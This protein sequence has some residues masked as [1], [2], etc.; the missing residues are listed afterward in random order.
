MRPASF[1][2]SLLPL[3][4]ATLLA[5]QANPV[6]EPP[7]DGQLTTPYRVEVLARDLHVPWAITFLP[8]R[9]IFFTERT[10]A[11]RV[12]H[13]DQLLPDA[14]LTIDVAQ[15]NKMGMLGLV[16]D[17]HFARNHFLY[18][19]YDYNVQPV[20]PAHPQYR[21]RIVRYVERKDKLI[22]PK[23]LLEDIPAWTNHTGGRMRFAPDGTL[24]ITTGDANE[25]PM[26]QRPDVLNGK[27][28]RIYSDGTVP[29]DNPFVHQRGA[30]PEIWS[31]GHRNP[32]GID[33][34]PGSGR[35]IETE[36]GPLGGDEVNWILPGHNYGWP[37]IDHRKTHEGMESP[38]LEFSPSIAPGTASFY[39]GKTFPELKGNV[40]VGCLRGEGILRI[41]L[42]G[43]NVRHASWLFHRTFG[44]IREITESPEGYLYIS[45]SQQDPVEG[46]PRP[47]DDDDLLM[48]VVPAS[49]P[50]SGHPTYTPSAASVAAHHRASTAP[51][52]GSAEGIIATRCSAC[53][54]P[55]MRVGMPQSVV[56][57]H[58]IYPM[59]DTAIRNIITHGIP[60][61]GMP[62]AQGLS[63]SDVSALI[64][65][66]RAQSK[67]P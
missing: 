8:D 40:L 4:F 53:H 3:A 6:G 51:A 29:A 55:Q 2:I 9:R 18:L 41:E 31:Y 24:Y 27:I 46:T 61:K 28:L 32:Q 20:D 63:D 56:G 50:T 66:L 17:P 52:P 39:R 7:R 33:F 62:A 37:V 25:P 44:R 19:A 5:L 59:D 26:A 35:V 14:A 47:G 15:G 13:N 54:G 22:E 58:W 36:H 12:M 1:L 48:R 60:E 43:A 10:G 64:A 11:V 16:A 23:V 49:L 21:M 42:D 67:A 45:T 38:L 34:E 57:N 65:Y 30:R